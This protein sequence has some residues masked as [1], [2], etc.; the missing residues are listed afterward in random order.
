M[1]KTMFGRFCF[2]GLKATKTAETTERSRR[3]NR[4]FFISFLVEYL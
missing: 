1:I 3:D 2:L 4:I